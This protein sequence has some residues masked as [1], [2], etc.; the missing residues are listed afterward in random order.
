MKEAIPM[1]RKT[2]III[3][4]VIVLAL[5]VLAALYGN[6]LIA[7]GMRAHRIPAH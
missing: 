2:V 4:I 5:C 3:A 6:D 1:N 7:M